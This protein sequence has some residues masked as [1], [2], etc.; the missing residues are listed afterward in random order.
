MGRKAKKPSTAR[1][2]F[3]GAALGAIGGAIAGLLTAPKSGKATRTDIK[4]KSKKAVTTA[5]KQ[6]KKVTRGRTPKKTAKA[7]K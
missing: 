2:F 5:K 7:R 4:R 6:V 1:G 3:V